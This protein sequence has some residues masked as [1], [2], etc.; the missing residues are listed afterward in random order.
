MT[1]ATLQWILTGM[2]LAGAILLAF[3]PRLEAGLALTIAPA[4]FLLVIYAFDRH[5]ED[6]LNSVVSTFDGEVQDARK[7]LRQA[8]DEAAAKAAEELGKLKAVVDDLKTRAG[9]LEVATTLGGR[10]V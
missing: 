4:V 2:M 10:R 7:D 8:V 3:G 9:N 1:R 6:E 5:T